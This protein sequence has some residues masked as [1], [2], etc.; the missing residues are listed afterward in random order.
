M[1]SSSVFRE[2]TLSCWFRLNLKALTPTN[3]HWARVGYGPFS[4]CVIYKESLC[5]SSGDINRLMK[6]RSFHNHIMANGLSAHHVSCV[7][8]INSGIPQIGNE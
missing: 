5:P 2:G 3:P 7:A 8:R 1:L 6:F 4:L